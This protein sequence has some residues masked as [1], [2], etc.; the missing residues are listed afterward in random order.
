[1]GL[2]T[3]PILHT[4]E[5]HG[6]R[7]WPSTAPPPH[8]EASSELHIRDQTHDFLPTMLLSARRH[9]RRL[10][11]KRRPLLALLTVLFLLDVLFLLYDRP[12]TT[13][14]TPQQ[15]TGEKPSVFIASV[16]RNTGSILPAWNAAVL[17]LVD[18][19][20]ADR[21]YFSAVES[22][23]QDDTKDKLVALKAELDGRGV[24]NTIDLGMDVWQQLDEMWARPDPDGP[25]QE[26]WIWNEEDHVYDLRRI[27]YLAKERNR[28]MKPLEDLAR[29]GT[30]FDK[31]LWINDVL[32]NVSAFLLLLSQLREVRNVRS[33]PYSISQVEDFVTLLRTNDG[34]YAAACSMDFKRSMEY[35]DTFAL[36]DDL[37]QKTATAFWP[38]FLSSSSRDSTKHSKPVQ[39]E[40]CWNGMVLFDAQPFYGSVPLRFRAVPDSLADL[41][42][43]G[44][45]CCLIHADN[46][47]S[48]QK[49]GGIWLNPNVRVAYNAT[50]Y[51]VV[52]GRHGEP[53]PGPLT[54]LVGA[55]AL[56]W[57]RWR[58]PLQQHLERASVMKKLKTW[59]AATPQGAPLREEP[60]VNCLI[61]EKQIMWMNG[62][63]HL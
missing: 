55:W 1:M 31:V 35:Y 9:L 15:Y 29:S 18:Y 27:T 40:S 43:E 56:R 4:S 51:S 12:R 49:D 23:S 11:R 53:F 26:G 2:L 60:G 5:H 20:G 52:Q 61:N 22:G 3:C 63:R 24:A 25:R 14:V 54:T 58:S 41:H 7:V 48:A 21:V 16:H 6:P 30:T 44:S 33:W 46:P 45:E 28:V 8:G 39:L 37:G 57:M 13:R 34:H 17:A 47:L 50:A 62:W 10:N 36:R 38:W 32:F 19:L 59:Q 42:L